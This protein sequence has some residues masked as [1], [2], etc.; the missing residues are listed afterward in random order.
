MGRFSTDEAVEEVAKEYTQESE[1]GH[2]PVWPAQDR[3]GSWV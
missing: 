3:K 2:E 1:A